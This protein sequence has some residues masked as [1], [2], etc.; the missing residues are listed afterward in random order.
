MRENMN[1]VVSYDHHDGRSGKVP[2][3][4]TLEKVPESRYGNK[5]YGN[6]CIGDEYLTSR[7]YDLRY[8]TGNLHLLMI[9]DYFGTGLCSVERSK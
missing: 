2:V 6:I 8:Q 1:W 3:T 5:T 9:E 7:T 4:T